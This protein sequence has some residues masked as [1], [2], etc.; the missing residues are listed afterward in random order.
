[1]RHRH[2]TAAAAL[3]CAAALSGTASALPAQ[4]AAKATGA[5]NPSSMLAALDATTAHYA[6]VAQRIWG[7]AEVGYMEIKSS[8]LL[9]SEL[10]AAG[11]TVTAG[12]A[13][14]P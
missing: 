13:G 11:F 5:A 2:T 7:F 10:T 9:Q 6:D 3:L 8:A 1:M 14:E 4:K 12:V